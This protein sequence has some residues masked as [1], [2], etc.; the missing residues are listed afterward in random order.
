MSYR[1]Q[2]IAEESKD[3]ILENVV[4]KSNK[5]AEVAS[6]TI[7]NSVFALV[8]N[9]VVLLILILIISLICLTYFRVI[10]LQKAAIVFTVWSVI[11][12]VLGIVVTTYIE[13]YVKKRLETTSN[14]FTNYIASED[15]L[16]LVNE[17]ATVYLNNV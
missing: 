15:A 7:I 9:V 14:I 10:S 12:I 5:L 6:S 13:M 2:P 17:A 1:T 16:L 3:Y 8:I 4:E 11:I